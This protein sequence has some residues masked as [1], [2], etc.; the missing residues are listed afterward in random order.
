MASDYEST[1][2]LNEQDQLAEEAD[3]RSRMSFLEHLDELRRRILYSI[4]AIAVSCAGTFY[5]W[6]DMYLYLITYFGGF[7]GQLM[8]TKPMAGFMFSLKVGVLSGLLVASPFVFSQLWLFVAPGLYAREK[9]VV[10]PFVFFS[11]IL[12]IGGAAFSHLVA[13]PSMYRFFASFQVPAVQGVSNG[14]LYFPTIDE[15]FSLYVKV[16]LGMGLV[17]QMPMLVFFLARF[18]VISAR[19]MISKFKYAVLIIFIIAAVITPSADIVTQLIFAGPMLILYGISIL[20]A[21][22]FGKK[23][24]EPAE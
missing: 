14:M 24:S 8:F 17:F 19:F 5:F 12:F 20:V 1:H 7:G 6:N 3:D 13:F 18:G 4:Y 21:W 23:R 10:V 2:A 11:T 9:R 15:T 22:V 16:I